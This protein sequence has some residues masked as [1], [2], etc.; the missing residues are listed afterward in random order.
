MFTFKTKYVAINHGARESIW[1]RRLLNKLLSEQAIRKMEILSD[2]KM[3]F[4]L[5]KDSK[6]QNCIKY[7]D[8]IYYHIQELITNGKLG[9]EWIFSSLILANGLTKALPT[10]FFK[11]YWDILGL[12]EWEELKSFW[13]LELI[14]QRREF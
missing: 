3:S 12:V 5:T 9:I 11:R 6:S 10:G 14:E 4:I 7:I 2:N 13:E 1:I 8:I